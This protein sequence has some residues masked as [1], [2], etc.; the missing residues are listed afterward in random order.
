MDA[1]TNP[2]HTDISKTITDENKGEPV[3]QHTVAERVF[4]L[5]QLLMVN[6]CTR[7]EIFE[8]LASYYRA[9][10]NVAGKASSSRRAARMLQ[11]D[12]KLLEEQGFEI[13]KVKGKGE[14]NTLQSGQ[15]LGTSHA[16]AF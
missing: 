10:E 12:I 7:L 2:L 3:M 4:R 15:R 16:T 11:R 14:T 5:L 13:R 8:H 9:G 6:E 1:D